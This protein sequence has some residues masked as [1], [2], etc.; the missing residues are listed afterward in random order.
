MRILKE[1]VAALMI[2]YQELL[3]PHIWQKEE[4]IKNTRILIQGLKALEVPII[5]S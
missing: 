4:L 5:V 1:D 3:V 2:D